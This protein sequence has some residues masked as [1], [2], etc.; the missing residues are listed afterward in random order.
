MGALSSASNVVAAVAHAASQGSEPLARIAGPR[1][2]RRPKPRR[3]DVC[4]NEYDATMEIHLRGQTRTFDCFECAI[5]AMAPTCVQ[6]GCRVIGHGA[7]ADGKIFCCRQCLRA[8]GVSEG[9]A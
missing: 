3:C 9:S 6:C 1:G 8:A 4:G 5:H 2:Q 7:E